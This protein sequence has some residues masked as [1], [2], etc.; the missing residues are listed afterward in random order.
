MKNRLPETITLPGA[1]DPHVHL[2]QPSANKAE[3]IESG[4]RALK[5]GGVVLACDMSNNPG[6]PTYY[7]DRLKEKH[8]I[9]KREAHI[10][11]ATA[12]GSQPEEDNLRYFGKMAPMAIF[13]KSY[14][15]KTTGNVSEYEPSDFSEIWT[16]WHE[17]APDKPIFV[18]R[19]T[20]DLQE[21][22][23]RVAKELDHHLHI[24]HVSN[25][26]EVKIV[27][28]AKVEGLP[29]S[30]EVCPHHLFMTSHD[31][32]TKGKF[33]EMMPPLADQ[34]DAEELWHQLQVGDIDAV[35]SDHAP[36]SKEAKMHAE[37]TD[38]ECYGVPG[39]EFTIP[40][41][42]AQ[43]DRYKI[44]MG[45]IE[46]VTSTNPLRILG[47]KRDPRTRV[48]WSTEK[49]RIEDEARQANSK[50]GWT[51]FL[52]ML[53]VGKVQE[54]TIGEQRIRLPWEKVSRVV[55]QRGEAI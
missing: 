21:I 49:Y 11:L 23:A 22:I 37:L 26:E 24:C 12:A 7:P 2:R 54:M 38:G 1:V 18:H 33:A 29:V 41:L 36:H 50:A 3:T 31:R 52:G 39:G 48:V 43:A 30:C 45:R 15:G 19:G 51:P 53:A 14:L 4:T 8:E 16:T 35:A 42:L 5:L 28:K 34:V 6:R 55:T 40:L 44:T 32:I 46:E 20:A 47:L 27:K 13:L 9:I 10:P 17:V 25:P